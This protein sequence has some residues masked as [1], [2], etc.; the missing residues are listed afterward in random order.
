MVGDIVLGA[1]TVIITGFL[2]GHLVERLGIPR[3][4]GMLIAGRS[5]VS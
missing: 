4:L 3:L 1:V 5:G 2:A